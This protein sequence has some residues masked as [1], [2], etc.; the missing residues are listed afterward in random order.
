MTVSPARRLGVAALAVAAVAVA[1]PAAVPPSAGAPA[2]VP[3]SSSP[4][5][6]ADLMTAAVTAAAANGRYTFLSTHRGEPVRWDPCAPIRFKVNRNGAVPASEVAHIVAAFRTLG[7]DLGGVRF[8]Y[9]GSTTLVPDTTDQAR[10]SGAPI[11]VAF[12]SPGTGSTRSSM[13]TG[14]EAG[15]GGFGST[16]WGSGDGPHVPVATTGA[17]VLDTRK[18]RAMKR[19]TRN[20]MYLHEIG[21]VL[22]LGHAG[23][24]REIMYP[25]LLTAGP[26]TYA[27]GDRAGLARL[28]RKAGCLQVPARATRPALKSSGDELVVAVRPVRSASG[29]VRYRLNS[30]DASRVDGLSSATPRFTV[31]L[32]ALRVGTRFRFSISA[33]NAVGRSTG[34]VTTF[35]F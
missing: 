26:R 35:T 14:R 34:P 1:A 16:R 33:T 18:A 29:P 17:A 10:R 27:S 8:L 2:D 23:D 22:G 4:G 3:A 28:G 15:R 30:P 25:T 7:R 32:D 12:A 21:H 24:R 9:A 31:P 19:K 5:V 20:A 6:T 13:L 11:V